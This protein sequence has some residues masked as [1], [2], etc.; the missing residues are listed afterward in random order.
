MIVVDPLAIAP[1]VRRK[2]QRQLTFRGV[3]ATPKWSDGARCY[4]SVL[5]RPDGNLRSRS[6]A[7]LVQDVLDVRGRRALGHHEL[8]CDLAI[9]QSLRDEHSYLRLSLSQWS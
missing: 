3:P 5:R 1:A 8:R 4:E 6:D 2:Q 7:K 9:R